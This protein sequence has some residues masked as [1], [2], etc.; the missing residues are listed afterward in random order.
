MTSN[1]LLQASQQLSHHNFQVSVLVTIEGGWECQHMANTCGLQYSSHG[2]MPIAANVRMSVLFEVYLSYAV[3]CCAH[4]TAAM[5]WRLAAALLQEPPA[6]SPL[7]E[8]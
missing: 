2:H 3:L 7:I 8:H 5:L 6:L 4:Q 1:T